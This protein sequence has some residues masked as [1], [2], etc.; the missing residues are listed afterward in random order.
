[1]VFI[2]ASRR[3]RRRSLPLRGGH[4]GGLCPF[5]NRG[6]DVGGLLIPM[7][8]KRHNSLHM[9]LP[10]FFSQVPALGFAP[11]RGTCTA[12]R[13]VWGKLKENNP[14]KH[15]QKNTSMAQAMHRR[16]SY[17]DLRRAAVKVTAVFC[18]H[19][20]N[21]RRSRGGLDGHLVVKTPN[22][23]LRRSL[24]GFGLGSGSPVWF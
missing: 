12:R 8:K 7:Q 13:S 3:S 24:V 19:A 15:T 16:R 6:G 22:P 23:H 11:L 2:A 9:R 20:Q 18:G 17:C 10:P 4:G 5:V 21:R 14:N 1:M